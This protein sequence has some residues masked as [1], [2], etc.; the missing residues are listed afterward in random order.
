MSSSAMIGLIWA[1]FGIIIFIIYVWPKF[2]KGFRE[3]V[4]ALLIFIVGLGIA[5]SLLQPIIKLLFG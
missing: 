1:V 4:E 5:F 3:I 2:P